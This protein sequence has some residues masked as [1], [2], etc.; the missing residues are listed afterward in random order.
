MLLNDAH[1]IKES[2]VKP[3]LDREN[4][5]QDCTAVGREEAV[6]VVVSGRLGR[7]RARL[8]ALNGFDDTAS[9]P[10]GTSILRGWS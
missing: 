5:E 1:P 3:S 4:C 2:I 8:Q 6:P 10:A 9:Y 7:A